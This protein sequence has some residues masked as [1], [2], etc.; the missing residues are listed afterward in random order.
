MTDIKGKSS[1]TKIMCLSNLT[2]D[3]SRTVEWWGKVNGT[4]KAGYSC[5][6]E[7]K[8]IR[9]KF[10]LIFKTLFQAYRNHKCKEQKFEASR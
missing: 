7:K 1:R 4:G 2:E 5:K 6:G 3:R 8:Q 10:Y 9:L